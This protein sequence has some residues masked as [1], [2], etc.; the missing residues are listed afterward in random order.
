M[1]LLKRLRSRLTHKISRDYLEDFVAAHGTRDLTLDI[2]CGTGLY[3]RYFP[4]WIGLDVINRGKAVL[5]GDAHRLPIKSSSIPVVITTEL[6]EHTQ[7]P[8]S[9]VDEIHRVLKSQGKL[10]LTTRFCFPLHDAPGD[11]YRFTKYGLRHLLRDWSGVDIRPETRT[12]E[13]IGVLIQRLAFQCQFK[14]GKSVTLLFLLAA[15]VFRFVDPVILKQYGDIERHFP[16]DVI[17]T[18]GYYVVAQK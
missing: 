5:I 14:G 2:G 16:E 6:L 4:R 10:L 18:T 15:R 1:R 8:Q 9:V 3:A 13:T 17:L 11:F 7:E 12:H